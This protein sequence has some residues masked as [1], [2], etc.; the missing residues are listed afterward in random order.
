MAASSIILPCQQG[1]NT[2]ETEI[3]QR[4]Y[5]H[6]SSFSYKKNLKLLGDVIREQLEH[7]QHF[8]GIEVSEK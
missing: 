4:D 6:R 2:N 7:S 5:I 3:N 8:F 1:G